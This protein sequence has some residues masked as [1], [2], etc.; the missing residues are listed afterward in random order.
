MASFSRAC[1]F[2]TVYAKYGSLVQL[3]VAAGEKEGDRAETWER[4]R[5]RV[6]KGEAGTH[7]AYGEKEYDREMGLG[8]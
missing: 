6:V 1:Y 3:E 8:G 7:M 5:G 2:S 4:W